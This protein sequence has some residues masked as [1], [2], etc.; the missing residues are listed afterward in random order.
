MYKAKT[1]VQKIYRLKEDPPIRVEK[2]KWLN[3]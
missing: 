3:P 1:E 2:S